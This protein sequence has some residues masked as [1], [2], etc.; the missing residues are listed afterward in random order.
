MIAL[1]EY[2]TSTVGSPAIK[3]GQIKVREMK[4]IMLC[5]WRLAYSPFLSSTAVRYMAHVYPTSPTHN[6]GMERI[7]VEWEFCFLGHAHSL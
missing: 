6:N 7:F 5:K 1:V 2:S 3:R 4:Q